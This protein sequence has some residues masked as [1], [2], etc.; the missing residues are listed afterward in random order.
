VVKPK[1]FGRK[2]VFAIDVVSFDL[3]QELGDIQIWIC[4]EPV[5]YG[6]GV[7]VSTF[8]SNLHSF[9]KIHQSPSGY[10]EENVKNFHGIDDD[11]VY[12]VLDFVATT[13]ETLNEIREREAWH[14]HFMHS[15]DDV[16]VGWHIFVVDDGSMKRI[17]WKGVGETCPPHHRDHVWST[18]LPAEEFIRIITDFAD[19]VGW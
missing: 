9:A 4:G 18:A 5:G 15:L 11:E 10:L 13:G 17:I 3:N 14:Y 7:F 2:E 16:V 8:A 6:Y 12:R 1:L 19:Y